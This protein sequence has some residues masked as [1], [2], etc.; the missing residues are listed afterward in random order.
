LI[1]QSIEITG[2]TLILQKLHHAY[3]RYHGGRHYDFAK[4]R[5][6]IV[7]LSDSMW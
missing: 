3:V 2:T 5:W 1:S 7:I 4:S 6:F